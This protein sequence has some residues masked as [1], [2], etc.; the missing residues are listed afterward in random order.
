MSLPGAILGLAALTNTFSELYKVH[1]RYVID[2]NSL[3][4]FRCPTK[5][6]GVFASGLNGISRP[7]IGV[8]SAGMNLSAVA[9]W[10]NF[11]SGIPASSNLL[12]MFNM[13]AQY[14]KGLSAYQP[15]FSRK[16]WVK[17]DPIK[18]D[19]PMEFNTFYAAK[20]EVWDACLTLLSY[21]Y[22]RHEAGVGDLLNNLSAK[23]GFVGKAI[24]NLDPTGSARSTLN[25]LFSLYTIPGPHLFHSAGSNKNKGDVVTVHVGSNIVFKSCYLTKVA[26]S[27]SPAMDASGYPL[28]A[29]V[30]VSLESMEAT[31]VDKDGQFNTSSLGSNAA[32]TSVSLAGME[33]ITP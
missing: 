17:T 3:V 8:L 16:Y 4:V 20:A 23:G 29:K 21:L 5:G 7:V 32:A 13:G 19:I 33:S 25:N 1:D 12:D 30:V 22:P 9:E 27:F 14:I 6:T 28:S 24:S 31:V 26:I 18:F 10:K 11:I 15:W 2:S